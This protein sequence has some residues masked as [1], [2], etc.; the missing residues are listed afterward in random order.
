MTCAECIDL[1]LVA[2]L[3]EANTLAIEDEA[4]DRA[5]D[6]STHLASCPNCTRITENLRVAER[7]LVLSLAASTAGSSPETIA[8]AAFE[9]RR[10]ARLFRWLL[11]PLVLV[12]VAIATL[13]F[14]GQFSPAI[15]RDTAPPPAVE[16][17]TFSL[18]CLSGEQAASLLRPYLPTPQNP[19]WQAEAFDVRPAGGGIRAVTVRA[20]HATLEQVPQLLAPFENNPNAEC[21]TP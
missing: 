5:A 6:I 14:V 10:R 3:G 20:P 18:Q 13:F 12:A 21:R 15:R 1:V 19:M 11:L 16:T 9:H 4:G 17:R 2:R 7:S 8:D